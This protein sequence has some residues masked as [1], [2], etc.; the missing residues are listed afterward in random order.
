MIVSTRDLH[1][2]EMRSQF[3]RYI[4]LPPVFNSVPSTS[5]A[6]SNT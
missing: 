2:L 6:G 1:L 3:M 5:F 4:N